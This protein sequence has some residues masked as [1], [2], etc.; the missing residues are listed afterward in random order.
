MTERLLIDL[1]DP[2]GVPL[3]R[4]AGPIAQRLTTLDGVRLALLDNRRPN[5]DLFLDRLDLQLR[6]RSSPKEIRRFRK[7]VVQ[8]PAPFL[9]ELA[10]YDAVVVAMVDMGAALMRTPPDAVELERRGVPTALLANRDVATQ[11]REILV[12]EGMPGLPVLSVA[13]IAQL[14][15]ADVPAL[16][17]DL[18]AAVPSLQRRA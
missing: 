5:A 16:A 11:C 1:V 10:T 13:P 4:P 18:V 8:L 12:T 15:P 17:D 3:H 9:D 14:R 7:P 6:E 2:V